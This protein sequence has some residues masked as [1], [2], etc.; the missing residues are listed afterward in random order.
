MPDV[1]NSKHFVNLTNGLELAPL[2]Q[3]QLQLPFRWVPL[4]LAA[5]DL[6]T[7]RAHIYVSPAPHPS[8]CIVSL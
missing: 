5:Q 4:Q 6:C 1:Y 3:Q 2:L 8:Q 7:T